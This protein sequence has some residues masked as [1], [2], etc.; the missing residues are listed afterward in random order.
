MTMKEEETKVVDR[1]RNDARRKLLKTL[2]A[3]GGVVATAKLMP[4]QWARP[5]VDSIMLPGHAQTTGNP[6]GSFTASGPLAMMAAPQET[7][8]ADSGFSEELLE[9]FT[10]AAQ[11]A[12]GCSDTALINA[13]IN[14]AG[15]ISVICANRD[16]SWDGFKTTV[17]TSTVPPTCTGGPLWGGNIVITGGRFEGGNWVLD[18]GCSSNVATDSI[19]LTP[20]GVGC[21]PLGD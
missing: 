11:A 9:F 10:P 5:V 6:F 1:T 7:M 3:G 18:Y 12:P 8:L 2:V 15:L 13:E 14:E 17:N 20:G 4:E 19:T 21:N 16:T